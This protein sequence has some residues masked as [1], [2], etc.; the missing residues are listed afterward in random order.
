MRVETVPPLCGI[1]GYNVNHG[2]QVL[3]G[4]GNKGEVVHIHWSS[5]E[6]ATNSHTKSRVFKFHQEIIYKQAIKQGGENSSLLYPLFDV[7]G[8]RLLTIPKHCTGSGLVPF[9]QDPPGVVFDTIGIK[10]VKETI[11]PYSVKSFLHV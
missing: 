11:V 5:T 10:L 2:L 7:E 9:P 8:V 3:R 4:R 6:Y 1:L